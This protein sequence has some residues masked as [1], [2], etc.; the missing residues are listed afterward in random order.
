MATHLIINDKKI[1]QLIEYPPAPFLVVIDQQIQIKKKERKKKKKKKTQGF[2][3]IKMQVLF[4]E[5]KKNSYS[6][7][8]AKR[9]FLFFSE[10]THTHI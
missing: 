7:I 3:S 9:S 10:K 5:G 2:L 1:L 8:G 6:T 4:K